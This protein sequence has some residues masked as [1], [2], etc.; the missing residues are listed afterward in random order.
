MKSLDM[1]D[2][3]FIYTQQRL[4]IMN[5][6]PLLQSLG[7]QG[8]PMDQKVATGSNASSTITP[9]DVAGENPYNALDSAKTPLLTSLGIAGRAVGK[10]LASIPDLFAGAVPKEANSQLSEMEQLAKLTGNKSLEAVLHKSNAHPLNE[11][12]I[13]AGVDKV[14][15]ATGVAK[16]VTKGEHLF[17]SAVENAA[18]FAVPIGGEAKLSNMAL[19]AAAGAVTGLTAEKAKQA[20][21]NDASSTVLGLL[22]GAATLATGH[23]TAKFGKNVAEALK[24]GPLVRDDGTLTDLGVKTGIDPKTA[25]QA[26]HEADVVTEANIRKHYDD[27]QSTKETLQQHKQDMIDAGGADHPVIAKLDEHINKI[28]E[29]LKTLDEHLGD[30][31]PAAPVDYVDA[32]AKDTRTP[33][34]RQQDATDVLGQPVSK[35]IAT[36]DVHQIAKEADLARADTPEGR[37]A[38]NIINDRNQAATDA[39]KSIGD[40]NDFMHMDTAE[41]GSFIA[42]T[43]NQAKQQAYD[44]V[45]SL[46]DKLD[47]T[48]KAPKVLAGDVKQKMLDA[49]NDQ[50]T[51]DAIRKALEQIAA[52]YKW[53]GK[54]VGK[55][56]FGHDLVAVNKSVVNPEGLV[57]TVPSHTLPIVGGLKD[58][59]LANAHQLD[60]ELNSL[61]KHGEHNPQLAIKSALRDAVDN[62]LKHYGDTD[63]KAALQA[64]EAQSAYRDFKRKF[65]NKDIIQSITDVKKGTDTP[66]VNPENIPDKIIGSNAKDVSALKKAKARLMVEQGTKAWEVIKAHTLGKIIDNAIDHNTGLVN[67]KKLNGIIAKLGH[68]KLK[69]IFGP[70]EYNQLMKLQRVVNDLALKG[71]TATLRDT[72]K[73]LHILYHGVKWGSLIFG[74]GATH[75]AS[76][77]MFAG[78]DLFKRSQMGKAAAQTLEELQGNFSSAKGAKPEAKPIVTKEMI[79]D[80]GKYLT[81]DDFSAPLLRGAINNSKDNN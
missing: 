71:Q 6:A 16:P 42:D 5:K 14:A 3:G 67:A 49:I 13:T 31:K 4:V 66:K 59:T 72:N 38:S 76:I 18:A 55:N 23:V 28:D 29:T 19:D 1:V 27:L 44:H 33:E 9:E 24:E 32:T 41:K 37:Q 45:K 46:F 8:T 77:G 26:Q 39:V 43:F 80:L 35:G 20:G 17:S 60:Q 22:A 21:A 73:L 68:D 81:S 64:R 54:H 48:Q 25:T 70:S 74:H 69:L 78:S 79:S 11:A 61:Y 15:D 10:G 75:A 30:N 2:H 50:K 63:T 62:T 7:F 51:P 36:Q 56:E 47:A 34:Q 58:L 57:Q 40:H 65:D 12:P 52:Q 53:V